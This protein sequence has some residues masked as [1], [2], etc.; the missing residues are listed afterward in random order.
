MPDTTGEEVND[1]RFKI[2]FQET[3]SPHRLIGYTKWCYPDEWQALMNWCE[4]QERDNLEINGDIDIHNPT[5]LPYIDS[6]GIDNPY[7]VYFHDD[8]ITGSTED[9]WVH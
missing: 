6:E 3:N 9:R 2:V 7:I 4:Q 5:L 8:W 1:T